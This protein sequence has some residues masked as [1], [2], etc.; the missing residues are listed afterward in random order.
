MQHERQDRDVGALPVLHAAAGI[1]AD[2][3][4]RGR[5]K[6]NSGRLLDRS[7]KNASPV[8]RSAAWPDGMIWFQ[9][10]PVSTDGEKRV[11]D[12]PAV[13]ECR[14]FVEDRILGC[15][16]PAGGCRTPSR[17]RCR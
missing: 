9:I 2:D 7:E 15:G 5:T 4:R 8:V 3:D 1:R 10:V 6:E 17:R 13:A 14:Q 12:L 11:V 16:G